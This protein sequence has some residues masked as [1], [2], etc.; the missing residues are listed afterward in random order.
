MI[1]SLSGN[2][3]MMAGLGFVFM[4]GKKIKKQGVNDEKIGISRKR[5]KRMRKN[6]GMI[7]TFMTMKDD[8]INTAAGLVKIDDI[9]V[10]SGKER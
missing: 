1:K 2:I 5:Q 8:D 6:R 10:I 7:A 4:K 3:Q 9:S